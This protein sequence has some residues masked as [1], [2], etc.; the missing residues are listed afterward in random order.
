MADFV[1]ISAVICDDVRKEVSNK[2]IIIGAYGGGIV[3]PSF[4]VNI[5]FSV[6]VE[7]M[8]TATG[9]QEIDVMFRV[10]GIPDNIRLRFLVDILTLNDPAT[11]YTPQVIMPVG[12]PG[13]IEVLMKPAET[14]EW[15]PVKTKRIMQGS[16]QPVT[17]MP[18]IV[19]GI[20]LGRDIRQGAPTAS[21]P[22]SEQSPDSVPEK[23]PSRARRR[24]SI[25]RPR[26]NP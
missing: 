9:H 12:A 2:D 7:I 18:E 25:R 10:P 23:K 11:F 21:P 3:V 1:V 19:P 13:N 6:W 14:E 16:P 20:P 5:P 22:P 17:A 26:A 8:P 4:P 24:P 15:R